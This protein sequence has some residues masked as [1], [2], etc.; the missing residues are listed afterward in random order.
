MK[1]YKLQNLCI[2]ENWF[3]GGSTEEY[4]RMFQL[5]GN[6]RVRL[7]DDDILL[8]SVALIIW[9]CSYD[10]DHEEVPLDKIKEK[11]LKTE[12]ETAE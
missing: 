10:E 12:A 2:K 11:L 5:N 6:G 7:N 9:L 3:T 8:H 1:N 4:R